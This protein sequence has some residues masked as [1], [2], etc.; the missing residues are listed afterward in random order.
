MIDQLAWLEGSWTGSAFGGTIDEVFGSPAGGS[1]LG[2]S[3][4]VAD[5][6]LVHREFIVL[7]EREGSLVYEVHLPNREPHVF[8]LA[9]LEATSVVWE[10]LANK[11]AQADQLHPSRRRDGCGCRRRCWPEGRAVYDEAAIMRVLRLWVMMPLASRSSLTVSTYQGIEPS[12]VPSSFWRT[13]A[14]KSE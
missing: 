4:V 2:T 9:R 11:L 6:A 1:V 14:V 8:R 3:R 13:A 7:A 10:D 5:G 12:K